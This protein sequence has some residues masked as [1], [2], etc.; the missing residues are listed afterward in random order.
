MRR[1]R[2]LGVS[3]IA[4]LLLALVASVLVQQGGWSPEISDGLVTV[5]LPHHPQ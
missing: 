5:E 3:A 4:V 1:L 2:V